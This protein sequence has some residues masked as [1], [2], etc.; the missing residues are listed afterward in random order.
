M[1]RR[2]R[3]PQRTI[4]DPTFGTFFYSGTIGGYPTIGPVMPPLP[5]FGEGW[6]NN[7]HAF[8]GSAIHGLGRRQ[9]D[10]SWWTIRGLEKLGL[11]WDVKV[12]SAGRI[13]RRAQASSV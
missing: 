10:M 12:P 7:H 11:A 8:P 6:H 3:T 13:A 1:H 2:G 5:T 4:L 9:V